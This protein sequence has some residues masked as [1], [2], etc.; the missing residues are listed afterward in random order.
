MVTGHACFTKAFFVALDWTYNLIGGLRIVAC[1]KEGKS[2]FHQ[3]LLFSEHEKTCYKIQMFFF[4]L[5]MDK[6]V[7]WKFRHL[8]SCART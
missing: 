4:N 8:K 1:M 2:I 5:L 7:A 6:K 3:F